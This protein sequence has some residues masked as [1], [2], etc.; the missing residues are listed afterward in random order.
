MATEYVLTQVASEIQQAIDNALNPDATLTEEGK[1]AD[2]KV[3]GDALAKAVTCTP[4]TLTDAEQAQARE[5]IGAEPIVSDE[6][7]KTWTQADY[8]EQQYTRG[9][10]IKNRP[11]YSDWENSGEALLDLEFTTDD[12]GEYSDSTTYDVVDTVVYGVRVTTDSIYSYENYYI[13]ASKEGGD[14]P[15]SWILHDGRDISF[16]LSSH[17]NFKFTGEPNCTYRLYVYAT[18]ENIVRLDPKYL[19]DEA[20]V[21]PD[22][23]Q[24]DPTALDYVQG[25]THW[26][27][28][29]KEVL[30]DADITGEQVGDTTWNATGGSRFEID[31]NTTYYVEFDG[32]ACECVYKDAYLYVTSDGVTLFALRPRDTYTKVIGGAVIDGTHHYKVTR[33]RD[34][35]HPLD[36]KFIPDTIQRTVT[37]TEGQIVGFDADGNAVAQDML[38]S[39]PT[40]TADDVGK[41]LRVSADGTWAVE[42]ITSATGVSF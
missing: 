32:V 37:G 36:Q 3:V 33:D 8:F 13:R 11:F 35:I 5:N 9:G 18:Q 23:N 4:Q 41:F 25:R 1:A 42:S 40:V 21:Q 31:A 19:P 29:A 26:V 20:T 14:S 24:S 12:N 15:V 39:L 10:Y 17:Y 38:T 2:A 22:W 28:T 34:I 30:L 7:R 6:D 16:E 27:E